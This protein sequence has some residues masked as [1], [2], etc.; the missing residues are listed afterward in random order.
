MFVLTLAS[1]NEAKAQYYSVNID[2]R[3][4]AAMVAAYGTGTAAEA[5]Y[6]AQ[7]KDIL[8]H[9]RTAEIAA[10]AVFSSK[11]LDRRAQTDL[12]IWASATENYYYRRIYNMVSAKIMPKIWTVGG[13]MLRNPQNALYWG[14]YLLKTCDDTKSLCMQFESVVTNSK[15]SF[16]DIAFLE[17][18]PRVADLL[19]LSDIGDV[20]FRSM[21]DA[22]GQAGENLTKEN[23]KTDMNTL[24]QKGVSLASSGISNLG[25]NLLQRSNFNDLFE[26]K[27]GS[28][29]TIV[30]N[31]QNLFQSFEQ[32]AGQT[33]L[34]LVGGEEGIANLFNISDYSLTSWID[35]YAREQMGQYY[36]Q[37]WYIYRIERGSKAV[38]QYIPPLESRE[39]Q[40]GSHWYRINTISSIYR[41]TSSELAAIK[42]NSESHAGWS[43]TKVNYLNSIDDGTQYSI[44]Y[45][46][47]DYGIRG[48]TF[49]EIKK[50]AFAY[51][52]SVTSTWNIEEEVYEDYFDSYSMDLSTFMAQ[53]N[54]RLSELNENEEDVTYYIGSD[55]KRY[56]QM[57]DEHK[58]EGIEAVTISVTCTDGAK[59]G[60]G[61]TQYKCSSCDGTLSSHTRDCSM[62][63]S[64]IEP[65]TDKS[66]LEDMESDLR[67][68]IDDLKSK[69]K[70][71]ENENSALLKQ[72]SGASIENAALLRQQYNDNKEKI[73]ELNTELS[74]YQSQLSEVTAAISDANS[75]D[76]TP[77]DD[78]RR[79]P[80]LMQECQQ[81]YNLIWQNTG[82]WSGYTFTRIAKLPDM[83]GT[84]TFKARLSITRKPKYFLWIKIHRAIVRIDWELYSEHTGSQVVDMLTLD[85]SMD[86]REKTD[87]VNRRISEV[88]RMYPSCTISTEYIKSDPVQEDDTEDTYHLLWSSDRLE[89]AREIDSRLTKIYA[90]L[91]SLEKM[92]SYKY[93]FID[94][95]RD[96][97]PLAGTEEGRRL[98]IA[99]ECRNQWINNARRGKE[100]DE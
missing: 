70:S 96:V 5:Y 43:Q 10:A 59:L 84:V 73:N 72:I 45:T 23:L 62:K 41:P 42:A 16:S 76:D 75:D 77:T 61:T 88:A 89:I 12:G 18:N 19:R 56:Y 38:M 26:G 63:T 81:T 79:I 8:K 35:D 68:K 54:A 78:Y 87:M 7:I 29:I 52:I 65:G 47:L 91:V 100:E 50:M 15:L 14:S 74:D 1:H 99:E 11:Y 2:A 40:N 90:D 46:L 64:I 44:Y 33:L 57:T 86:E 17:L 24:Y 98:S 92:M 13:M 69:I 97:S 30:D 34:N 48:G 6:N 27:I 51:C 37:R 93:R 28:A 58:L 60:E 85:S 22:F 55:E 49:N 32:N 83:S 4:A 95:L 80:A 3:T 31:Y 66:E 21:L 53:L 82:S 71:L 67:K 94:F 39:I 20:D 36:T 25:E 9:Y